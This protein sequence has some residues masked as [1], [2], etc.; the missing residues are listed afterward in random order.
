MGR[1]Y[2]ESITVVTWFLVKGLVVVVFAFDAAFVDC[3]EAARTTI[4]QARNQSF[5]SS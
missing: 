3:V 2:H 4:G 1:I 5:L